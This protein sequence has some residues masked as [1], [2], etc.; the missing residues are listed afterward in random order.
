M[1]F[2]LRLEYANV[3]YKFSLK[4]IYACFWAL[5]CKCQRL[6]GVFGSSKTNFSKVQYIWD[7]LQLTDCKKSA[8]FTSY[9]YLKFKCCITARQ[10]AVIGLENMLTICYFFGNLSLMLINVMLA[11]KKHVIF[12]NKKI[13]VYWIVWKYFFLIFYIRFNKIE[14]HGM[15]VSVFLKIGKWDVLNYF[16]LS[17]YFLYNWDPEFTR[18]SQE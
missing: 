15:W 7:Y 14:V 6:Y 1:L 13:V 3:L 11:N 12:E 9:D 17:Y 10:Y 18:C 4:I 5:F 16:I 8:F 2:D